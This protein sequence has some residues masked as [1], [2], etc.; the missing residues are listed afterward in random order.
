MSGRYVVEFCD[1]NGHRRIIHEFDAAEGPVS[2][3]MKAIKVFCDGKLYIAPYIRYW[4]EPTG[5]TV[6]DVGSHVEFFYL[7][8]AENPPCGG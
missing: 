6:F 1:R 3:A 5:E 4:H 2:E 7:R 8:A